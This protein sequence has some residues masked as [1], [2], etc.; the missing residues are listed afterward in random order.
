[1]VVLRGLPDPGQ[2]LFDHQAF[3]FSGRPQDQTLGRDDRA[4][5]DQR[6]SPNDT[7]LA[8]HRPIHDDGPHSDQDPILDHATVQYHVVAARHVVADDAWGSSVREME[9]AE[10]L[11][12]RAVPDPTRV[13]V[14]ADAWGDPRA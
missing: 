1:D 6:A 8:D 7:V 5:G 13:A 4:F 2:L 10:G 11:D 12:V 3:D 9:R 14:P